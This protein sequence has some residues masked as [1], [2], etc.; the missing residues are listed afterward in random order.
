MARIA[1]YRGRIAGA[2]ERELERL[3]RDWLPETPFAGEVFA[4]GG[5]VR[6]ELLRTEPHDLDIV[7]EQMYGAQRFADELADTWPESVSEPQPVSLDFPIW[8]LSFIDDVTWQG[9]TY[10]VGGAALDIADT[11]TMVTRNGVESTEFGSVVDD[12]RRR[13]FTVNMLFKDLTTGEI[14]D[15]TGAGVSAVEEGVLRAHPAADPRERFRVQPKQMLRAVRFMLRYD[16]IIDPDIEAAMRSEAPALAEI[17]RRSVEKEF[18]KLRNE[19]LLTEAMEYFIDFGFI[20]YLKLA[21][22]NV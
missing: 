4:V 12:V 2:Q 14:V 17:S 8:N 6:D 21:V 9:A 5:Y 20:P 7:V 10:R 16:W 19:G 3:F 11:Q 1:F 13:D 18:K 15:P 22:Q